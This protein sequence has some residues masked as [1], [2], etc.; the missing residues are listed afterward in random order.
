MRTIETIVYKFGELSERAQQKAINHLSDINVTH[1]WYD[2]IFDE[3]K[4]LGFQITEF[5]ERKIKGNRI[6]SM[7]EISRK[8][9]E[10]H[11]EDCETIQNRAKFLN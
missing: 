2:F 8:I 6:D 9:M 11:C 10:D 4:N 3:V 5:D 7:S 1:E